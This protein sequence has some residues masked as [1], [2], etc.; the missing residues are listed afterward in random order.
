MPPIVLRCFSL[1][2]RDTYPWLIIFFFFCHVFASNDVYLHR[3]IFISVLSP[4][5]FHFYH[6]TCTARN[7]LFHFPC[8]CSLA[9]HVNALTRSIGYI[10]RGFF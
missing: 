6:G 7:S 9:P 5:L 1:G 3:F 10:L 2:I 8:T 4:V